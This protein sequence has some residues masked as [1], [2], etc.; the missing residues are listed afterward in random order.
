M[1]LNTAKEKQFD[2]LAVKDLQ[3]PQWNIPDIFQRFQKELLMGA[4][5]NEINPRLV[6][7]RLNQLVSGPLNFMISYKKQAYDSLEDAKMDSV[8]QESSV[9]Q[10][11]ELLR[12][13]RRRA[14]DTK[15]EKV[16]KLN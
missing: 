13:L 1:D 15:F 6:F 7:I 2:I 5:V 12:D 11:F 9:L 4:P 16:F 14:F 8:L 10:D 3:L